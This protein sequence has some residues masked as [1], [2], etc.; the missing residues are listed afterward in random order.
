M[1]EVLLRHHRSI[2]L[3]VFLVT[4]AGLVAATRLPVT[5]FPHIDYP[6][7]VVS[8]D[9]GERDAEQMAADITRPAEIAL[10]A[11]PGVT[12]IRSTTSRGSAE[13]ALTFGWGDDMVAATL[14]TQGALATIL[15]DLPTG[16]RFSVRRSD[17]TIFP[18]LGI[19]L[20]SAK[21]DGMSLHQLAQLR[22]L[23]VLSSLPGVAGVDVLG[24]STPEVEVEVDPVRLQALGLAVS[25][26]VTAVGA[27]NSVAA[28]GRIEDR[29]R[30]Y[31]ALVE[32][33]LHSEADI[34]GIPIKAGSTAGAGVT[35]LGEIATVRR[36]PAP[37]WTRVTSNGADA[38]LLNIRQTPTADA[39]ALVKEV[40][41]RLK[42]V[43]LPPDVKLSPFYDQSELG[44]PPQCATQSCW[45]RF[46]R[47]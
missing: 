46:W 1:R 36:A 32:D 13:V 14:A 28:V 39:V 27:A 33:R 45:A 21:R 35:T 47:A 40:N 23:P 22:L 31:L 9:A 16:A 30:L 44:R 24:G 11:V 34:R 17:P 38:V 20:T 26:V 25:D 41:Q 6:R 5:L 8:I 42:S 7:V 4:I 15:P 29:H 2:W 43:A 3:S 12:R 10:R 19:S 37:I 18:V